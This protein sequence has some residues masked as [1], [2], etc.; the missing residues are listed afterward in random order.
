MTIVV[1]CVPTEEAEEA[2]VDAYFGQLLWAA[3]RMCQRTT[4]LQSSQMP[5]A[6]SGETMCSSHTTYLPATMEDAT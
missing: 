5:M 6:D 1:A 2:V 4:S 3:T